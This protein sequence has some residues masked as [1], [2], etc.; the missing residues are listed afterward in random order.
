[1][2]RP[3]SC[4]RSTY[5]PA[6]RGC[7]CSI[8]SGPSAS[9]SLLDERLAEP[10]RRRLLDLARPAAVMGSGGSLTVFTGASAVD[11]EPRA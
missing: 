11:E 4:S 9:A 7:R 1:M 6:R 8:V 10:E 2:W 5:R 3:V